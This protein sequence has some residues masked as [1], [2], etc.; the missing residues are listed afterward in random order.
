MNSQ[1]EQPS[2]PWY[3]YGM[4]WMVIL[5]PLTVVVASMITIAIAIN[6]APTIVEKGT[7]NHSGQEKTNLL[8]DRNST[9]TTKD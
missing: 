5:L 2:L 4:V 3:R 8:I 1:T 7:T 9:V 6:N